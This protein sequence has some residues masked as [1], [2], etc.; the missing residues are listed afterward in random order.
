MWP[1]ECPKA[2]RGSCGCSME[3]QGEGRMARLGGGH[4]PHEYRCFLITRGKGGSFFLSA[5]RSSGSELSMGMTGSV[6]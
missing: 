1:H 4:R 2:K 3:K 5:V 6:E